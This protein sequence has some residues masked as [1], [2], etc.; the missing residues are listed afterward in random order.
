M[1]LKHIPL[2]DLK[3]SKTNVRK[4]G[5]KDIAD[6]IPSIKAHGILQPLLVRANGKG[7]E[8]IAGQRRYRAC[9]ALAEE[10][11][12]A[13]VPCII[14]ADG[15]DAA[16]LE[17][18][19]AEN[20]MRL[21]MDELDQYEAFSALVAKD[22]SVP[23]IAAHFGVTEQLVNKRLAL[24][25]LISPIKTLYRKDKIGA[26]LLRVLTLANVAQQ[27]TWLDLFKSGEHCAEHAHWVK[28]WLFDGEGIGT[29][30]ALFPLEQYTGGIVSDLFEETAYFAD[31]GQFWTLQNAA[32][33]E[34][35]E[36][37]KGDDWKAVTVMEAGERFYSWD[38]VKSDKDEGGKV[39]IET[40]HDGTV[41]VH[42]GFVSRDEHSARLRKEASGGEDK[43]KA[44]KPELTG[45]QAN[46]LHLHRHAAV[47]LA[48][49]NTPAVALRL[50]VAHMIGGS[51]LWSVKPET[52]RPANDRIAASITNNK[53]VAA[54][55]AIRASVSEKLDV[56]E[57]GD[58]CQPG[59]GRRTEALFRALMEMDDEAV[60]TVLAYAMAET[61]QCGTAMVDRLGDL[62]DVDMAEHW[63]MDAT[64]IDHCRDREALLA[65][66]K[67]TAG[68]EAAKANATA[69][70]K[71]LKAILYAAVTGDGRPKAEGW[72]PPYMAFP[73]QGYT[74]RFSF[75]TA[76]PQEE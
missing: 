72:L 3:V 69:P 56:A 14:M 7:F 21:P 48:V 12:I 11:V 71:T 17:A 1:E 70:M 39:F 52:A 31:I 41:T 57:G 44:A 19:L 13:P 8:I 43:P 28:R 76:E 67:E 50:A 37:L 27:K 34:L 32:I 46:Y 15:D 20:V 60:N 55:D 73:A 51:A 74:E 64:F 38:Y 58:L 63:Q 47:R 61:L 30:K 5:G 26:A 42:E 9:S 36:K 22:I 4:H 68:E 23:D 29:D 10:T 35:A 45:P 2:S 75:P 18:S 65:M 66:V 53:A 6:L 59:L 33:T 62:L 49:A 25:N 40:A 24:A 54:L 16:A